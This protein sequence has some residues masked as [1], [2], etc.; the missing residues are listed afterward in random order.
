MSQKNPKIEK[1]L[2]KNGVYNPVLSE[3][4]RQ[5]YK[6]SR[7]FKENPINKFINS[8][9]KEKSEQNKNI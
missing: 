9:F 3:I 4:V 5:Q 6:N 8:I 1:Y 2:D 7:V